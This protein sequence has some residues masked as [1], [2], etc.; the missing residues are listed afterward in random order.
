MTAGQAL[1]LATRGPRFP[2]ISSSSVPPPP[3]RQDGEPV[4]TQSWQH[5]GIG[6]A[7]RLH[8]SHTTVRTGPYTAVRLVER[9]STTPGSVTH[10]P[11]PMVRPFPAAVGASP[12]L[13]SRKASYAG[14]LPLSTC[15]NHVPSPRQPFGPSKSARS[16]TM[17]SA[18][19]CTAFMV[20]CGSL[21]PIFETRCRPPGVSS[22]AFTAHLPDLQPCPLVD[23]DF[24]IRC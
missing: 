13:S 19:S 16:S 12:L 7:S 17:P 21:S 24:A 4:G 22:T 8:P 5:I 23:M 6:G 3:I 10:A 9:P 18:D 14:F 11:P 15:E 2:C 1:S 20:P